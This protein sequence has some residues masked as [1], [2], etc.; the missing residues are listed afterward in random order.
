KTVDGQTD[1]SNPDPAWAPMVAKEQVDQ[2]HEEAK[3]SAVGQAAGAGVQAYA[4]TLPNDG[5]NA[6]ELVQPKNIERF[7]A[8]TFTW[9]G[10]NNYSDDPNVTVERKVGSDWVTFA[11]QSGEV[12]VTLKYPE[13]SA[14]TYDPAA[15]GNGVVG[16]RAGGQVWKW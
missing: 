1:P 11:D 8:A 2:Q 9:D 13:S 10:G 3:V 4:L 7:D 15:I 12:P 5:G 6:D 16:Y 14:G